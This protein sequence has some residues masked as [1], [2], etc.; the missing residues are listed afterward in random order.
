MRIVNVKDWE[1]ND[2]ALFQGT[3]IL[4]EKLRKIRKNI[5]RDSR[6][7]V[8]RSNQGLPEYETEVLTTTPWCSVWP[9]WTLNFF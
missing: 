6:L 9:K 4:L 1:G 3:S 8:W 5:I 7:P 2:L